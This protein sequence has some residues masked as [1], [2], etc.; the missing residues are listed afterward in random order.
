MTPL[1]QLQ[2][3]HKEDK[4]AQ[5]AAYHKTDRHVIGISNPEIDTLVRNW[6]AENDMSGRLSIA[7]DLWSSGVFEARIAAA[8]LLVQARIKDD[9]PVWQE[10]QSWVP[11]FDGWALA[12]HACKAGERRLLSDPTR[13]D[14]VENW[15]K[16]DHMWSRR[17]ALVM[18]LP[19]AKLRHPSASE[20]EIRERI[21][22]WAAEY[23]TDRD[24]F[25]QKAIGW[26]LRTLS[27]KDA[28][29]V[30]RFIAE[31][32]TNM[33]PFARREA[34]RKIPKSSPA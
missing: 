28:P 26:W 8:K 14:F 7:H 11:E 9:G 21:L 32:G 31:Y 4:A 22:G 12:D 29:R 34:L 18:T 5:M 16:S 23:S 24:W 1:E 27:I 20:T 13:L 15:T 6:K 10:I 17:A 25:I 30:E 3:F 2:T 33:K 19:W